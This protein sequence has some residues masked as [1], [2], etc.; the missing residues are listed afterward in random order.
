MLADRTRVDAFT[1]FV[2]DAEP[3]LRNALCAAFGPE[4]GREATADALAFAWE[5][6]ERVRGMANPIGYLWGVGRNK[7]RR[8][9]RRRA[10]GFDAPTAIGLPW[11]EPGLPGALAKLTGRQRVA[12]M[13][14][15]GMEW[16]LAEVAEVLGISK[17]SAQNHVE[18][19]IRRLRRLLGVER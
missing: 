6:W 11:V 1:D 2:K 12:V 17:T 4:A 16:T 8:Q 13:L 5:H 9:L 18:R 10:I 14:V 15:Y 19:G 7:A 3:R